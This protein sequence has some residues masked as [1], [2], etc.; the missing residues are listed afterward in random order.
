[1]KKILVFLSIMVSSTGLG[2]NTNS[3]TQVIAIESESADDHTLIT[4]KIQGS[5]LE[6]IEKPK[7]HSTFIEIILPKTKSPIEGEFFDGNSPF[8]RKIALFAIGNDSLGMR[9]FPSQ[10][11]N[12]LMNSLSV[13][14][15]DG[16]ILVHLDHKTVPPPITGIPT[17]E[18][19]I[20]NT[21][22]RNDAVDPVA[23]MPVKVNKQ[24]TEKKPPENSVLEIPQFD[25]SVLSDDLLQDKMIYATVFIAF[26]I[27]F[28]VGSLIAKKMLSSKSKYMNKDNPIIQPV[29]NYQINP[30]Q[31]ITVLEISNQ[32]VLVGI[33]GETINYLTTIDD[34]AS[35]V[36]NDPSKS[37]IVQ[38]QLPKTLNHD[39]STQ[40]LN[41]T[42]HQPSRLKQEIKNTAYN[43]KQDARPKLEDNN[44]TIN[45]S[46]SVYSSIG[47]SENE[48]RSIEDVTNLIRKKLKNLPK[49]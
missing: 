43:N 13:Q 39:V 49:V 35:Q 20:A 7:A 47:S 45:R 3:A 38:P 48:N 31:K 22:V 14:P 40:K 25:S 24:E 44:E 32:K 33:S 34:R 21:E 5:V 37:Q 4:A 10:E 8:I 17:V 11:P 18:E 1:M 2:Q 29:G 30:K 6:N 26:M 16:R 46:N 15:L 41:K 27:L 28:G 36:S 9:I 12:T 19:V 42:K 23:A